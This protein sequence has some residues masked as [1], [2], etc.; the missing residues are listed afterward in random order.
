M[1]DS[2]VRGIDDAVSS[3][4]KSEGQDGSFVTGWLMI[5]SV[6]SPDHDSTH[7]DGY[8]TVTSD[9]LPHHTQI[10]LLNVALDD[11]RALSMFSA[12]GAIA[13]NMTIDEEDEDEL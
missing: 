9:G 11:K 3:Y 1:S 4:I 5:A 12:M 2:N 10:G 8:V 6:S 13:V 7:T